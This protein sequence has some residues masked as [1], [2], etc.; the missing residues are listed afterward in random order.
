MT[1]DAK[2]ALLG[3]ITNLL[4]DLR[5]GGA[6]NGEAMFLLG[7]AAAELTKPGQHGTWRQFKAAL[8]PAEIVDYLQQID[9]E[10][11]RL[12]DEDKVTLA[13]ALQ[14]VGMSLAV[15]RDDSP[16]LQEGVSFL[17]DIIE[18]TLVNYQAYIRAR[19]HA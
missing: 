9:R 10:G 7:S 6:D 18:Q 4:H 11:N 19:K 13:Y 12:L 16:E 3:K 14:I 8:S 15:T 1:T 2:T 5:S 17:D